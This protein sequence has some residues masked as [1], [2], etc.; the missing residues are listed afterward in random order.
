MR[1]GRQGGCGLQ[2]GAPREHVGL[3]VCRL[4][5]LARRGRELVIMIMMIMMVMM[6]AQPISSS[7]S[8]SHAGP[9]WNRIRSAAERGCALLLG[10]DR[11]AYQI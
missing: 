6:I 7:A 8:H 9:Y 3:I 10:P 5:P 1:A 4:C 11:D 2:A